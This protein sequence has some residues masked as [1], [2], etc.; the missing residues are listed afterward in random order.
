M[1][2]LNN[3]ETFLKILTKN[4]ILNSL[5][6]PVK[7]IK[8]VFL[9]KENI[10]FFDNLLME[11]KL[12][13][14]LIQEYRYLKS[15]EEYLLDDKNKFNKI[16][17]LSCEKNYVDRYFYP[18]MFNMLLFPDFTFKQILTHSINKYIDIKIKT[19]IF[20]NNNV[21]IK[22]MCDKIKE[23]TNINFCSKNRFVEEEIIEIS[24]QMKSDN[25]TFII[26]LPYED[27]KN[28]KNMNN[29]S[30]YDYSY[31]GFELFIEDYNKIQ[32]EIR[33]IKI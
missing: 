7:N 22:D 5:L 16:E 32:E 26:S 15:K 27:L 20:D 6:N 21:D 1:N 13:E 17:D 2:S 14:N 29:I 25:I 11:R 28:F 10:H 18:N 3:R 19:N 24:K 9:K 23:K 12:K 4:N 30:I 33:K 8:I 31:D